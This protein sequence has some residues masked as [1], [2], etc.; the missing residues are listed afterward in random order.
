MALRTVVRDVCLIAGAAVA[1][2]PVS[3]LPCVIA[4]DVAIV[5][6]R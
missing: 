4:R 2:H 3:H 6:K 5:W 1:R